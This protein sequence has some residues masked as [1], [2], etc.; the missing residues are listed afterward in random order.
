MKARTLI[1][2]FVAYLLGA[3]IVG[4]MPKEYYSLGYF[5]VVCVVT[6]LCVPLLRTQQLFEVHARVAEGIVVGTVGIVLWIVLCQLKLEQWIASHIYLPPF[7]RPSERASFNPFV[8]LAG[9][10]WLYPFIATRF[11]GLAILVP[12]IEEVFWRGFLAKWLI[13]EE[14]EKVPTGEFTGFSFTYVTLL[15]TLAHPEWFAAATY[16]VLINGLLWWRRDLFQCVVAHSVSN[17]VLGC[18]VL[19]TASWE[20]W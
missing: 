6:A 8:E 3:S 2:P 9:S 10:P 1:L 13:S 15:F 20:L 7:L 19:A 17:F 5:F 14:W 18:Y 16:A 12:L 11:F 4:M